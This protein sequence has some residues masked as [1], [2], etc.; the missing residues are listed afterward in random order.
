MWYACTFLQSEAGGRPLLQMRA[1]HSQC[2][3]PTGKSGYLEL[4]G[5]E[6]AAASLQSSQE[7]SVAT[8]KVHTSRAYGT[9]ERSKP[10]IDPAPSPVNS[11]GN[12]I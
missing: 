11:S 4:Q 8:H 5:Q 12:R 6:L 10:E 7:R 9:P 1:V 3:P 2:L